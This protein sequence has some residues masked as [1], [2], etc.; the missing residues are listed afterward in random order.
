M[1]RSS[2]KHTIVSLTAPPCLDN[3]PLT[4]AVT[5]LFLFF[6]LNG[7]LRF[8]DRKSIYAFILSSLEI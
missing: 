6:R 2:Y 8:A 3:P 1:S 7:S 5:F 4:L